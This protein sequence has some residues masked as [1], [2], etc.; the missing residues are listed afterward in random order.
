MI[1]M[2]ICASFVALFCGCGFRYSPYYGQQSP[3]DKCRTNFDC[4]ANEYCAK[5]NGYYQCEKS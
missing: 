3:Y 2:I 1:K 5:S 4:H